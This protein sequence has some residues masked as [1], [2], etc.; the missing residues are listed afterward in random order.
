MKRLH[1]HHIFRGVIALLTILFL[2]LAVTSGTFAWQSISQQAVNA[3]WG[4]PEEI[5]IYV[6]T[7]TPTPTP[8]PTPTPGQPTPTPTPPVSPTP[9]PSPQPPI[10][11]YPYPSPTPTPYPPP[12]TP[13]PV[14]PSPT[15]GAPGDPGKP[16]D[17]NRPGAPGDPN[18][19]GETIPETGDAATIGLWITLTGIS[20]IGLAGSV[21]VGVKM[22]NRY[23]PKYADGGSR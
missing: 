8:S 5:T 9:T 17:P 22:R 4:E 1:P 19:P 15:P 23:T 12:G 7:P 14:P 20:V 10:D 16:G 6:P 3:T 21:A 11:T 13:T 2:A 18:R